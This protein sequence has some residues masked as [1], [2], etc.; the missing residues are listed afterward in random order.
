MPTSQVCAGVS[1]RSASSSPPWA[2]RSPLRLLRT[3]LPHTV[4]AA[5]AGLGAEAE[6]RREL[7]HVRGAEGLA[8]L[9]PATRRR[10]GADRAVHRRAA[11]GR[12]GAGRRSAG[13]GQAHHDQRPTRCEAAR[14]GQ[15]ELPAARAGSALGRRF[16]LRFDLVGLV[17]HR[18][19][20]RPWKGFD[21][22]ELANYR[23]TAFTEALGPSVSHTRTRPY[24]PQTNGKV[25]R[26]HRTL[27]DE[28]AYARP[29]RSDTERCDAY[30]TWLHNYNHHRGHT[31]LGGRPPASRVTNLSGQYI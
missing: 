12:A 7:R 3:P 21:G 11:H 1:S 31:A 24:R 2:A 16:H 26:F 13:Q 28:W 27:A 8:D 25:E 6:D 10:R 20:R 17:L 30:P 19:R 4:Q 14:P 9:E 18:V 22:L 5:G 29:Y 15:P 23:S